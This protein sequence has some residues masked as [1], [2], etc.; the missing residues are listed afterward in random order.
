M[1]LSKLNTKLGNISN[2]FSSKLPVQINES[3]YVGTS[4][5]EISTNLIV[6]HAIVVNWL[7]LNWL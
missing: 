7:K 2:I 1:K 4:I 5:L 3:F 6:L